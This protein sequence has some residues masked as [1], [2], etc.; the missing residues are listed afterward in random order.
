L[1]LRIKF[2]VE[3]NIDVW[4]SP[5]IPTLPNFKPWPNVNML[6]LP[7][8]TVAGLI[9]LGVR[10]WNSQLLCDLFDPDLVHN[11]LNI[12]IPQVTSFDKWSWAPSP[13]G[14]F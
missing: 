1:L 2:F 9:I 5:W 4:S 7:P 11:I 14:L 12:H 13:L 8:F 3:L 6:E 10:S